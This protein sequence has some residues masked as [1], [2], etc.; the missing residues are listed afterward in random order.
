[1]TT[2]TDPLSRGPADTGA[3]GGP[4]GVAVDH[5]TTRGRA[6][7]RWRRWRWPL[8]AAVVV[9]LAG[10]ALALST[11]GSNGG[12]L[13]PGSATPKG[14]RAVAQIL[15]RQ[16]VSLTRITRSTSLPAP[17]QGGTTV[18]VVHPELL[19]PRQLDR[20]ADLTGQ[21]VL[22][23]PDATTLSRVAW[24]AV[25]AGTV[26]A[27]DGEP[28]C[29]DP[30]ASTAGTARTGGRLYRLRVPLQT[31]DVCYPQPGEPGV[32]GMLRQTLSSR[33][34]TVL[35]Q[36]DVLRNGH[37]AE[38]GN[39][40]LALQLLGS[41]PDLIWYVPDPL[42]LSAAQKPPALL[43]LAPAWVPWVELQIVVTVLAALLWRARRLG[44]LVDEPLP[45]VV[46]SAETQEGR[47]RL[48]RQAGARDRAAA[49]LRTAAARRLAARLDVPP[50]A[51]PRAVVT[52][53]AEVTG[54]PAEQVHQTLLGPPPHDDAALVR[55]ADQLDELEHAVASGRPG[56]ARPATQP[57]PP[58]PAPAPDPSQRKAPP[59]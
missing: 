56:G 42:E 36:G 26:P 51:D 50:E 9:L 3:D 33:R 30:A 12:D 57:P 45:V 55:L 46:R 6:R 14:S 27:R 48:Y 5:S 7:E 44:R 31:V 20:L 15:Q 39:A 52:L 23:E 28:A 58:G 29:A 2:T 18:V 11:P 41:Q 25:V 43:D 10:L 49:T 54:R 47:A 8:A 4:G 19:G 1:M 35:G 22:V 40:A 32:G 38:Q 16:G 37:L 24:F 21:L 59:R 17:D 13:D 53:A 34:I